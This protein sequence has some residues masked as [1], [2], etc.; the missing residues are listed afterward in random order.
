METVKGL[1]PVYA[2]ECMSYSCEVLETNGRNL[3]KILTSLTAV[4]RPLSS[5]TP[6]R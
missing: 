5:C 1:P 3:R 4:T 6:V 2:N